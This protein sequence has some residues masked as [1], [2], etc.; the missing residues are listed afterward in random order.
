M[1]G[2]LGLRPLTN[3]SPFLPGDKDHDYRHKS[4]LPPPHNKLGLRTI[5]EEKG[6]GGLH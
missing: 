1:K 5:Y 6:G 4:T 3:L 2:E